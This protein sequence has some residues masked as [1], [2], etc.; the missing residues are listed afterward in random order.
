VPHAL[1]DTRA[2]NSEHGAR[3]APGRNESLLDLLAAA[4]ARSLVEQL[5]AAY[6]FAI[7][8]AIAAEIRALRVL[9]A[10]YWS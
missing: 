5:R 2:H 9:V 3:R 10:Q 7:A 4:H 8:V 1:R 6:G